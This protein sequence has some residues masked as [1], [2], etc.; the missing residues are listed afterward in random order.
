MG[1]FAHWIRNSLLVT[2]FG[3]LGHTGASALAAFGFARTR[4]PGRDKLFVL[5]LATMMIPFQVVLVPQYIM[6]LQFK[7]LD[8]LYP[9]IVPSLFGSALYIFILRQFF[10]SL[11]LELDEAAAIDGASKLQ[12]LLRVAMPL[13]K[14]ALATVA[15]FAFIERWNEFTTPLVFIQTSEN[16]TLPVGMMWF[17][18]RFDTYFHLLMAGAVF[19]VTPIVLAF[20]FAQKQFI[21]G[22]ALTGIKG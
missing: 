15:V 5:V 17:R 13:S 2:G 9:I 8:T 21:R 18:G 7:W 6:F 11:P 4:F 14:P 20:F 19:T 12:I 3:V 10:R 1:P 16:L 22:I